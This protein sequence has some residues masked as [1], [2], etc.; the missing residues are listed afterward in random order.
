MSRLQ[1]PSSNG[2]ENEESGVDLLDEV[3]ANTQP[4]VQARAYTTAAPVCQQRRLAQVERRLIEEANLAGE[5]FYYGW[6]A[7]KDRIEGASVKLAVAMARC[8]GNCAVDSLP[9]QDIGDSW[10]FTAVF[11]D[12]ETGFTLTRQFRQSKKWMVYGKHDQERKDDIRFQIGQ[13]KATRNVILNAMPEYIVAKAMDAAKAGVRAKIDAYVKTN[14]LAA[15]VDLTL[16]GLAKVGVTETRVLAR[17]GV[18]S[19]NGIDIDALVMLRGDVAAIDNG[20]ER[21]SDLFPEPAADGAAAPLQTGRQRIK[22]EPKPETAA[23]TSESTAPKPEEPKPTAPAAT[24]EQQIRANEFLEEIRDAGDRDIL[25]EISGRLGKS[26]ELLGPLY[27][28]V[29]DA[30]SAA[31]NGMK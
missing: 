5:S 7:G 29:S 6:G 23:P 21:A 11:I 24:D 12:L 8:Y 13:S 26:K 9:V 19:K 10:I 3:L 4:A 16:K 20:Q 30:Y 25:M 15:A 18:A 27:V 28:S 22:K 31:I 2:H 1:L 17:V 14:G